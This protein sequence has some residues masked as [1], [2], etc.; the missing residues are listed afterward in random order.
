MKKSIFSLLLAALAL[1]NCSKDEEAVVTPVVDQP[2]FTIYATPDSRTA[3]DGMNTKWVAGD[4][5]NVFH[6]ET[7]STEYV[8]VQGLS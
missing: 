8:N 3:N 5:V 6:A 7:G 1:T 4:E 2:A